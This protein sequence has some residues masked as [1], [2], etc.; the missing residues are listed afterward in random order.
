M[1][2]VNNKFKIKEYIIMT[3]MWNIHLDLIN[4]EEEIDRLILRRNTER[5]VNEKE[6]LEKEVDRLLAR[7]L[8]LKHKL[9]RIEIDL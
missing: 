2:V 4:I 5:L 9:E 7:E 8:E 3:N 1:Y 6:R